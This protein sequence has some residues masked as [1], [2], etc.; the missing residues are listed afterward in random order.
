MTPVKPPGE[1]WHGICSC[2]WESMNTEPP[3]SNLARNCNTMVHPCAP[4]W[5]LPVDSGALRVASAAAAALSIAAAEDRPGFRLFWMR[6]D[7]LRTFDLPALGDEH[8]VIGRH[9]SCDFVL[10]RDETVSLR[11]LLARVIVLDDGVP[12]LRLLDLQTNMPFQLEDGIP[13]R[14]IVA[15]GPVVFRLGSYALGA[16]P[17]EPGR[18]PERAD[19]APLIVEATSSPH[20]SPA[21]RRRTHITVLPPPPELALAP[22][23]RSPP[24][25]ARPGAPVSEVAHASATTRL[26]LARGAYRAVAEIGDQDLDTGVIVGRAER[27]VGALRPVLHNAVSRAHLLLLRERAEL[28]AYDLCSTQGTYANGGRVRRCRLTSGAV[29]E[30][31]RRDP[32]EL[33]YER[34]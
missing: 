30:L 6:G 18:R 16:L 20:E 23:Y 13:R 25:H 8:A 32:V 24:R 2:R 12:A 34:C 29:L 1:G 9:T 14:S 10:E 19:E 28:F 5:C 21:R 3:C 11:H 26:T 17:Y 33:T 15:V 22:S 7:E 27:C 31:A 4:N